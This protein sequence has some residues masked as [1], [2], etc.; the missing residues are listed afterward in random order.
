MLV[1]MLH[2][3]TYIF[4]DSTQGSR[5]SVAISQALAE[6]LATHGE[7]EEGRG[8]LQ[9]AMD[10]LETR[11][12]QRSTRGG[13]GGS[14]DPST[15]PGGRPKKRSAEEAED[16]DQGVTALLMAW[17][18]FEES[19]SFCFSSLQ[20]KRSQRLCRLLQPAWS[21]SERIFELNR[22]RRRR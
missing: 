21:H 16:A 19:V 1:D 2:T 17:A 4:T 18:N 15:A 20:V 11:S 13:D 12:S 7:V 3:H 8:L 9:K 14:P 5:Q 6:L 22:K 10:R